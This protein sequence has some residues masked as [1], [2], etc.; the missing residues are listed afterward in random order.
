[1]GPGAISVVAVG[2]DAQS[3][4]ATFQ[5]V[6]AGPEALADALRA[7]PEAFRRERCVVAFDVSGALAPCDPAA[8]V[9][10]RIAPRAP[11]D[12]VHDRGLPHEGTVM[13][14][15][16]GHNTLGNEL[17]PLDVARLRDVAATLPRGA[18]VVITAVGSMVDDQHE[19]TAADIVRRAG[20]PESIVLSSSFFA[21]S[22]SERERTAILNGRL[23]ASAEDLTEAISSAASDVMP[24]ARLFC[25]VDE[26]GS[27][28]LSR[29]A[30]MPVHSLASHRA[31]ALMGA[32]SIVGARDGRIV[33]AREDGAVLGELI[34]GLP[35]VVGK[36]ELRG[37]SV[38]SICAH[39]APVSD[40]LL[41]GHDG[42]PATVAWGDASRT[43]AYFGLAPS[44]S[45]TVDLVALGAAVAPLSYWRQRLVSV[46]NSDE[47]AK[48]LGEARA[49]ATA[50]LVSFGAALPD[51]TVTEAQVVG[52]TY[53]DPQVVRVRVRAVA[54]LSDS[55]LA[56]SGAATI[57]E[58]SASWN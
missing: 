44:A 56:G 42:A 11:I 35:T 31:N 18:V 58:G 45:T 7:L 37:I 19:R 47:I 14:I 20:A 17:A 21:N 8:L 13:H 4:E 6:G 1:V 55:V 39:T 48:A 43:L 27:A 29:L 10:V 51:V 32:A 38:A 24:H 41:G 16:G 57:A 33:I 49:L 9:V 30:V 34:R 46:R 23:L 12:P 25:S 28:P 3:V 52:G 50:R 5:T 15:E 2:H 36:T 22:V 54:E 26:G 40:A 53:G